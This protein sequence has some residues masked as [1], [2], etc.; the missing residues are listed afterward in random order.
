[1]S[2]SGAEFGAA[3]SPEITTN[4]GVENPAF[5]VH[6]PLVRSL[7]PGGILTVLKNRSPL[8]SNG[9]DETYFLCTNPE[10]NFIYTNYSHGTEDL[11]AF[12]LFPQD[13]NNMK[14]EEGNGWH[15][16]GLFEVTIPPD[17]VIDYS[18]YMFV[19]PQ[20]WE[21]VG[22]S[23]TAAEAQERLAERGFDR[24]AIEGE[25]ERK[26]EEF[27]RIREEILHFLLTP[28]NPLVT[29]EA[30]WDKFDRKF[31]S[32]YDDQNFTHPYQRDWLNSGIK[33][34]LA[35]YKSHLSNLK[36]SQEEKEA[37]FRA[38][39][40]FDPV[41]GILLQNYARSQSIIEFLRDISTPT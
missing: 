27:L 24:V 16:P 11:G 20:D 4:H 33:K 9:L 18:K 36:G 34:D 10:G 2:D 7:D 19:R 8:N 28:E 12:V 6:W 30:L 5:Q 31:I 32:W 13:V 21:I 41:A 26:C 23:Q 39:N 25:I 38:G 14:P 3:L 35:W 22:T 15:Q 29:N 1:M 17:S 37:N 40:V